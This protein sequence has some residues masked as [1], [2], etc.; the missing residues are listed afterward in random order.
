[1]H[2]AEHGS[3]RRRRQGARSPV[4]RVL[5]QHTEGVSKGGAGSSEAAAGGEG[6]GEV[7]GGE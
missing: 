6:R 5:R 7:E 1:M 3:P 2:P 4:D